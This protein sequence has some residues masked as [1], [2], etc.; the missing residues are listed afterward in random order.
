[1]AIGNAIKLVLNRD[2]TT[3]GMSP[4]ETE[5]R[6][7]LWWQICILD[8]REAEDHGT[9]PCI[10]ER[11]FNTKLPLNVDDVSLDPEMSELPPSRS[12]RTEMLFSLVR[13]E[14][15]YFVRQ[16]VFS[17]QF[18]HE[19]SYP[20]LSHDQ[21][22]KAID[23]LQERIEKQYLTHCDKNV[24]FDIVTVTEARL[25]ILKLKLMI[26]NLP[27]I[28]QDAAILRL[29]PSPT[30]ICTEILQHSF[31]LRHHSKVRQWAWLFHFY[32]EADTLILLLR[33][34][35]LEPCGDDAE[36]AWNLVDKIWGLWS[37]QRDAQTS[38]GWK[39]FEYLRSKALAVRKGNQVIGDPTRAMIVKDAENVVCR[40]PRSPMSGRVLPAGKRPVDDDISD[41]AEG[42]RSLLKRQNTTSQSHT[43]AGS[44]SLRSLEDVL[45]NP[46]PS[47]HKPH[48]ESAS[49]EIDFASEYE[50][51]PAIFQH[52]FQS[53]DLEPRPITGW[54]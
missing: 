41:P 14:I 53:L 30:R 10:L 15:S 2:G 44:A 22:C 48:A 52:Y 13:F 47:I 46:R 43:V 9:E 45:P 24:L 25:V 39:N 50:W 40:E 18:C 26:R 4:F 38:R 16:L 29:E 7:R 6:R 23:T 28:S 54:L 17:D 35:H 11:S 5:M 21:K 33:Q 32:V 31:K 3:M 34:L 27:K 19:N 12:G 36:M 1:M 20:V 49:E 37:T 42:C 51:S 8:V